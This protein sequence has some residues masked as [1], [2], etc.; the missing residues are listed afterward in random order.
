[1]HDRVLGSSQVL[2]ALFIFVCVAEADSRAIW[3]FPQPA[4]RVPDCP[5]MWQAFASD[6]LPVLE[7]YYTLCHVC[8][9]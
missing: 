9:A 2:V 3:P 7:Y 1:M 4:L 6:H 8:K 5:C